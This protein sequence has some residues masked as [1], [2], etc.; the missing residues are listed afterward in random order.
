MFCSTLTFSVHIQHSTVIRSRPNTEMKDTGDPLYHFNIVK[1]SKINLT[2]NQNKCIL[3]D[4]CLTCVWNILKH[5]LCFT[6]STTRGSHRITQTLSH[7][8]RFVGTK[9]ETLGGFPRKNSRMCYK[10]IAGLYRVDILVVLELY[11]VD[12]FSF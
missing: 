8:L 9:I 11:S 3:S 12:Y 6:Y 5:H 4:A 2:G 1:N 7:F 10:N